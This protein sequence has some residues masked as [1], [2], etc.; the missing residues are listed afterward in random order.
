M[1]LQYQSLGLFGVLVA[2]QISSKCLLRIR[3]GTSPPQILASLVSS[4]SAYI[5]HNIS[6]LVDGIFLGGD[7]SGKPGF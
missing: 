5:L 1:A 4:R 7:S 6:D 2:V 3:Y